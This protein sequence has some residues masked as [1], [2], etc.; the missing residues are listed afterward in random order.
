ML[1]YNILCDKMA[2]QQQYG[3]APTAALA[4][5]NRRE[6]IMTELRTHSPDFICLQ[7]VDL[8][9][10]NEHFRPTL[11][12]DDYKGFLFQRTRAQTMSDKDSKYVDGCAIFYKNSKCVYL[13]HLMLLSA[14]DFDPDT[15]SW[16]SRSLNSAESQSTGPT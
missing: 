9:S 8:E 7:E 16:T 15:Y 5:E 3:Y 4:W 12:Y 2:T 10:Y 11:A 1:S 13:L 14:A 6:L